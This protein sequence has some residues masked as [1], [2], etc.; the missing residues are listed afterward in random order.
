MADRILERETETSITRQGSAT[1]GNS[2]QTMQKSLEPAFE[3]RPLRRNNA[4]RERITGV[5]L[6]AM[7]AAVA[8]VLV[9]AQQSGFAFLLA[10]CGLAVIGIG[11]IADQ[12]LPKADTVLVI[13][14]GP[15]AAVIASTI[16]TRA[17]VKRPI[18]V[19]RATTQAEAV[20][21]VRSVECNEIIVAGL[22][23]RLTVDLVDARG[24]R[25]A[26]VSGPEKLEVLLGR[27]PIELATQDKW[28]S[29]LGHVRSLSPGFART[30]RAIDLAFS[31]SLG[32]IVLPLFPIIALA[33]KLD[34]PGSV[35]YSQE[36]VGLGGRLFRIYK[37]RTMRRDAE[38][39][40]AVWAQAQD[41]RIT[42]TGRFMRL[43]RFDE[44]PQIWNVILG[45][46]AV[47]GPR[48]ERPEFTEI[49]AS[50]IP[51]YDLRH[52]VKPGLT[53]WAQVCYRY[54]SSIRDTRA[55]VEYDLYYVKHLSVWFDL[56]ILV[57]TIKV[58]IGMQGR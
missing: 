14:H 32:L 51:G 58:V 5:V 48:P 13:G 46:M 6:P 19:V 54:T 18:S 55:K 38:R 12:I 21:L 2:V 20:R 52:T 42:R 33:I 25:P 4:H 17:T 26:V 22:N 3:I 23:E 11:L 7:L 10:L 24:F 27:I 9:I 28:L 56:Q 16:E 37:F 29:R 15:M 44:L 39:D 30:K 43:T 36:R 53:G 34:S 50:E 49:L 31:I 47:V 45:D 40:G 8:T 57:R 1:G 35:F 41:D